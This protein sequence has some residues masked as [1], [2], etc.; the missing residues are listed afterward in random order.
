MLMKIP[1]LYFLIIPILFLF[2][3]SVT[4]TTYAA[5]EDL[6]FLKNQNGVTQNTQ[7]FDAFIDNA[8]EEV[9]ST[10]PMVN[11]IVT[12][13]LSI[14]FLVGVIKMGYA[15]VTKTGMVLK[16]S[17]GVLIG[18]PIFVLTLRLFFIL[19]FTTNKQGVT[20]L[21]IDGMNL[22]V[23]VGLFVSIGMVL[24][25]LLMRL[26]HKFLNHP[27]YARWSKRLYIGAAWLCL[28]TS[29][30]PIVIRSI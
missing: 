21:V 15:L 9:N 7:N 23:R 30:M 3:S 2:V 25:G 16:G 19:S 14:M 28:L 17:T 27:E 4:S 29:V 22:L 26:F 20:L 10:A 8:T 24:I 13:L 5:T 6:P 12:T 11:T 1:K 18:I